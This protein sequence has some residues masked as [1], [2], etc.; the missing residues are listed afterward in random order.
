MKVRK[1]TG[2]QDRKQKRQSFLKEG[3]EGGRE[4]VGASWIHSP[5]ERGGEGQS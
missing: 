1:Y 4:S 5:Q 2:L 3:L